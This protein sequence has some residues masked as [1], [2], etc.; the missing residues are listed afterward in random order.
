MPDGVAALHD[1]GVALSGVGFPFCGIRYVDG[2]LVAEGSFPGSTGLGIRRIELHR[3]LL[4]RAERVGVDLCWDTAV[5]GLGRGSDG[6]WEEVRTSR[7]VY[8]CR[9]LVGADGLRSRVRRWVGLEGSSE[10]AEHRRFGVRRHFTIR[11]WTPRVEV[12]WAED[13]EAYVTP[14]AEDEVGVAILW[15]GRKAG[16]DTLLSSFP[17]LRGRLT[18]APAISRDR[19]C[20][21]LRQRALAPTRHNV[22][23]VGDA[24]GYV[25]AITGE[26]LSLALHQAKALADALV[27]AD[28][29]TYRRRCRRITRLPDATTELLLRIKRFPSLRRRLISTLAQDPEAFSRLLAVHSRQRPFLATAIPLLPRL[30]L[31]LRPGRGPIPDPARREG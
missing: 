4:R 20:G 7:G 21:P 29:R 25:D 30:L 9:W 14:V 23:L 22:A 6:R 8:G 15:S 17:R 11:P 31:G 18:G 27:R 2:E 28:L 5:E 16:F 26:G 10:P 19:G 1:L 24:S 13:C 12:H 3:A